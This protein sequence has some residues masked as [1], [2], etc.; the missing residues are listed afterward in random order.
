M[1]NLTQ[2]ARENF[3]VCV[4]MIILCAI[5]IILRLLLRVSLGQKL[6]QSDWLCIACYVVFVG[7][8]ALLINHIFRVSKLKAF[9]TMF[10]GSP[11]IPLEESLDFLKMA[12]IAEV[13]FTTSITLVKLSI[14]AFYWTLFGVNDLQKKL[15]IGTTA[16][17]VAWFIAFILLIVFQCKPIDAL[18]TR[19][20]E[21]ELC[22]SSPVVLLAVEITNLVIDVIILCIPAFVVGSL[23]L[24][25]V[26]KW[27]VLGM[28][29]LGAGVCVF[30]IV[31]LTVIW[32]PP[33]VLLNFNAAKTLLWSTIQ[34]GTAII[35][36]CLPTLGP[37]FSG[38]A[39]LS[40]GSRSWYGS[41]RN[42]NNASNGY[43]MSD[44]QSANH[45]RPWVDNTTEERYHSS[46][47]GWAT[48]ENDTSGDSDHVPLDP[49]PAKQ[50]RVQRDIHV[51]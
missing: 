34:L 28:F 10:L 47:A 38:S 45:G 11:E 31:R 20:M 23:R 19:P 39:N 1:T 33:D 9:G 3:A 2:D 37:L 5:T 36:A 12:W 8:C 44:H 50:I 30:S 25:K 43:K 26:K 14:L 6:F 21:T 32:Q 29:L 16:L 48:H 24:N 42:R 18:W 40:S 49:L 15:I 27:S 7:Y 51:R 13:L 4:A 22:I 46:A 41:M 35:C 17:S